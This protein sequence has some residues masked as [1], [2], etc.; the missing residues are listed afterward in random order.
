MKLF[1]LSAGQKLLAALHS[2]FLEVVQKYS[3]MGPSGHA[4]S[5]ATSSP[6]LDLNWDCKQAPKGTAGLLEPDNIFLV[7]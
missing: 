6:A 1:H 5:R 7:T 2:A 4:L 3:A